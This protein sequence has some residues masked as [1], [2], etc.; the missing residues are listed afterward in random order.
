MCALSRQR[1]GLTTKLIKESDMAIQE[2]K[3]NEV[4]EVFGGKW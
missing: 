1:Q 4:N 2:L 3:A